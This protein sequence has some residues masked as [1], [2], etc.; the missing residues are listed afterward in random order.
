M[1]FL[2]NLGNHNSGSINDRCVR[3]VSIDFSQVVLLAYQILLKSVIFSYESLVGF[4]WFYP[5]SSFYPIYLTKYLI[6]HLK[7]FFVYYKLLAS[8]IVNK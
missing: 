7:L 6:R 4:I 1:V 8:V 3:V 2:E 5:N